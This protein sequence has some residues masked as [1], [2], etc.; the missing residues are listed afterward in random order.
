MTSK[1]QQ[2]YCFVISPIGDEGS[3]IRKRSDQVFNYI[4][5]PAVKKF[6]LKPIRSDQIA[7]PG[8]ITTQI[9]EHLMN[10][11]LVIADLTNQNA[12]VF[13]EL[14]IR[15]MFQKPLI[16][17]M[18]KGQKLPFD[19]H[20]VRTIFLDTSDMDSV[21]ECK[22]ILPVM[23][24]ETLKESSPADNP[25]SRVIELD[26]LRSSENPQEQSEAKIMTMLQNIQTTVGE[27]QR[28][29]DK[30]PQERALL[31]QLRVIEMTLGMLKTRLLLLQHDVGDDMLHSNIFSSYNTVVL[32][33]VDIIG[34]FPYDSLTE[35]MLKATK[36]LLIFK[37]G[38]TF[39]SIT[40]DDKGLTNGAKRTY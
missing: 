3:A 18:E 19:V 13:Y 22:R 16:Q 29:I 17:M 33:L 9:I 4:I 38:S 23:I 24:E 39:V 15:H 27:V 36:R 31:S 30:P 40:D 20:D 6:K 11:P 5:T 21:E 28:V 35:S 25:I 1:Q 7:S 8:L 37:D 26:R 14:A 10:A 12:N 2:K 32:A 34:E